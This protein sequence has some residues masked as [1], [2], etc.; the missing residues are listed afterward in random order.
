MDYG[1]NLITGSDL[2]VP[3]CQLV[4]HQPTIRELSYIGEETYTYGVQ[5]L[6]INKNM[7]F[8][9]EIGLE[10]QSNFQI[11][12]TV[13]NQAQLKEKKEQVIEVLKLLLPDYSCVFTPRS[14]L[15]TRPGESKMIDEGNFDAFQNAISQIFCVSGMGGADSYNPQSAKAKEIA[16]KLMRGRQRVAAQRQGESHGIVAQYLSVLSVG[17]HIPLTQLADMTMYQLYDLVQRYNLYVSWDL[18]IRA[19]MAGGKPDGEPE[20]WMKSIH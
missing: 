13:M 4:I 5:F 6:C 10:D 15:C 1:L 14:I 7:F 19:R 12:M 11:F 16:A 17:L 8:E 18:D 3:E 2:P 20:N 9:D